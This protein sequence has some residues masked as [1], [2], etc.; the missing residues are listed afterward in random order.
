[1]GAMCW[2]RKHKYSTISI[3][4]YSFHALDMTT[5]SI[6]QYKQ[7]IFVFGKFYV[8]YVMLQLM[9]KDI[10]VNPAFVLT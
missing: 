10:N 4:F 1:M 3:Q 8:V 9:V 2:K 6:Q 7:Y 5:M